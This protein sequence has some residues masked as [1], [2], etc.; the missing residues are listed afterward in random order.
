MAEVNFHIFIK[1]DP[2][3]GIFDDHA[4]I[5]IKDSL[6]YE[7]QDVDNLRK[8]IASIYD[9]TSKSVKTELE[10]AREMLVEAEQTKL[11]YEETNELA[12]IIVDDIR[13]LKDKIKFLESEYTKQNF[14]FE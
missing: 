8:S 14:W 7:Q 4:T 13:I 11:L 6:C 2:S 3:V 10:H 5:A 12:N 1:G 9:V